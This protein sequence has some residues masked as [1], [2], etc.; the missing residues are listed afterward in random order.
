MPKVPNR[1]TFTLWNSSPNAKIRWCMAPHLNGLHHRLSMV[2]WLQCHPEYCLPP[3]ENASL[4]PLHL[5][6]TP[7]QLKNSQN[8]TLGIS[9]DFMD[10]H[11]LLYQIEDHSL[12]QTSGLLFVL[13]FGS[14]PSYQHPT[15]L[16]LMAKLNGSTQSWN[17][18]SEPQSTTFKTT[19][20]HGFTLQSLLETMSHRKQ[21][22]CPRSSQ[23]M[24]TTH[25]GTSTLLQQ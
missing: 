25:S 1:T 7:A 5:A 18:T 21:Q 11:R 4:Y 6:R 22:A 17:N 19:G 13:T 24:A 9:S 3:H 14:R 8:S 2:G 12:L 10:F 15:T 16:R 23:T 20:N